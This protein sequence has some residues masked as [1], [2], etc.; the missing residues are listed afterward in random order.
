MRILSTTYIALLALLCCGEASAQLERLVMPG[1]VIEGHA[2][3]ESDCEACHGHP[4]RPAAGPTCVS[5]ATQRS[6]KIVVRLADST[7]F[8]PRR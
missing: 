7:G 5:P 3:T 6:A 1:R 8:I 2:E 4:I